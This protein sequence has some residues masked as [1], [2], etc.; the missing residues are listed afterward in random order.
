[1]SARVED[2]PRALPAPIDVRLGELLAAKAAPGAGVIVA[3]TAELLSC[4]RLRGRSSLLIEE[5]AGRP[6][7]GAEDEG[8]SESAPLPKAR[9]W[10]AALRASGL[11]GD[12]RV[13][14]PLVLTPGGRVYLHRYWRAERR[15]T[16]RIRARLAAPPEEEDFDRLAPL[17]RRLFTGAR[18]RPDLRSVAAAAVLRGRFAVLSGGP[19][20]GKTTAVAQIIALLLERDPGA[21]IALA[22]PTG[23]AA[24]RLSAAVAGPSSLTDTL[25]ARPPAPACTLHRLLDYSP[26]EDR[27]R[28]NA[29]HPLAA[30]AVILDEASMVDLLLMDAL[31]DAVSPHARILLVGDS[32][33][34]ASVETGYVLGDLCAAAQPPGKSPAFAAAWSRLSGDTLPA[35]RAVSS[36]RDACVE[37]AWNWRFSE[38]QRIGAFAE[39][40][41]AGR[42]EAACATLE[43]A[44]EDLIH[45]SPARC[46]RAAQA[47]EE[48]LPELRRVVEA[49]DADE[50]LQSLSDIRILCAVRRGPWGVE[51]FNAAAEEALRRCGHPA[52][53]LFYPGRP[54][55][56]TASDYALSL[57]NGDLGVLWPKDGALC[58]W[59]RRPDGT[60]RSI[61][62][63]RLPPHETAWAMTVHKAQG[64][65]FGSVLLVLPDRDSPLLTRELLYTGIT[66]ARRAVRLLASS[67][68]I[69]LCVARSAARPSG[70]CEGLT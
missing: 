53:G 46:P 66:R 32:G 1:M 25:R 35:G 45:L 64:S 23:K 65:E 44:G 24:A 12:G 38:Q 54:V 37:L 52:R 15:L 10:I 69:A 41:R 21:R 3:R 20:T 39:A 55:L 49:S 56:I 63:P 61:A 42:A 7:A 51:A 9:E 29:E 67:Q 26:R 22:A 62:P 11:A 14:T 18:E 43:A 34:L 28:R 68:T 8:R 58:A 60:L 36:L 30:D 40:V 31:F 13:V 19:G 16:E 6:P 48:L 27:F 4:E 33:Q 59:F 5:W 17:F 57:F 70:L 47:V 50:A 2:A